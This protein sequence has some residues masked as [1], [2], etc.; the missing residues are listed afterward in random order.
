MRKADRT[1]VDSLV[2]PTKELEISR[3]PEN[4]FRSL[5]ESK[6]FTCPH[7]GLTFPQF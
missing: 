1:V 5:L 7:G 3:N 4:N 2:V 6:E